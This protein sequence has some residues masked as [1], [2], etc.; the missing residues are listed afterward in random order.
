MS[1]LDIA[2]LVPVVGEVADGANGII[3]SVRGDAT[4]AA[5]SFG[6]MI[7]VA[8][9]A[10]TGG[11]FAVKGK[12]LYQVRNVVSTENVTSTYSP[13]YQDVVSS[14]LG[15]TQNQLD[16]LSTNYYRTGTDAFAFNMPFAKMDIPTNI[17]SGNIDVGAKGNVP[18]GYYQDASGRWHRPDGGYASNKEVGLPEASG[19]SRRSE[20]MG[21]TPGKSSRTGK[22]VIERMKNEDPPKIRTTR[23]GRTEFV[24][25][26]G[27]WYPLNEA[28]MAHLTDAVSWWNSTGKHYGAKS[29]EVR[30]WMLDSNNYV[31]DHYS[32]NRSAGGEL[33]E[34]YLPPIK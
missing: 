18:K 21:A 6:A 9:W 10:S 1:V 8:G 27:K 33:T 29:P 28:D 22:E 14:S 13:I 7:P 15:K 2:G 32:L 31:L 24:A 16:L 5:L 23:N 30:E 12:D 3:Y 4:N 25:S 20:Y 17:K 26:D 19:L 11:K 34:T